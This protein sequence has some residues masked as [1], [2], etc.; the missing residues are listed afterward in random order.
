MIKGLGISNSNNVD[1]IC[2]VI[3]DRLNMACA[4]LMGANLAYVVSKKFYCEATIGSK[5]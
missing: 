4:S 1:L 2:D 5:N 3:R